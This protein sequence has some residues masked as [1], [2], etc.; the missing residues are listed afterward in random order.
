MEADKF[1]ELVLEAFQRKVVADVPVPPNIDTI[2][3][4]AERGIDAR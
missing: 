2:S 4:Y 1:E 3:V